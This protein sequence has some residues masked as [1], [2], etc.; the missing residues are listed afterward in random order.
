[1]VNDQG[2]GDRGYNPSSYFCWFTGRASLSVQMC[3]GRVASSLSQNN[4]L[5]PQ[6]RGGR[7]QLRMPKKYKSRKV[8]IQQQ[9]N[10]Q[11]V[12]EVRAHP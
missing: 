12:R 7:L 2:I 5:V 1:M 4:V 9:E 3:C 10:E 6:W 11:G 8:K